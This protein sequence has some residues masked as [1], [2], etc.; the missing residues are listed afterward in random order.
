MWEFN[1][2]GGYL[3]N[4]AGA[5]EKGTYT[6]SKDKLTLNSVTNEERP[7]QVFKITKLDSVSMHL[8]AES[9]NNKT[10]LTFVKL[11]GEATAEKD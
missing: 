8:F 10:T 7:D 6:I 4:V 1:D 2:K 9:E 11:K 5:V 3:V